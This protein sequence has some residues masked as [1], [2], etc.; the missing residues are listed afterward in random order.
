M[1]FEQQKK[2]LIKTCKNIL[3]EGKA[4]LI[5]GFTSGENELGCIPHFIRDDEGL[6]TLKWDKECTPNLAKYLLDRKNNNTAIIA[7]P[8]DARAIVMYMAESQI[9]RNSVYIIG[10]ECTGMENKEGKPSP[11]CAECTV[12]TPPVYDVLI[13]NQDLDMKTI[14][15]KKEEKSLDSEDRLARFQN[16]ISKCILC[17]SCRQACY[18]CYCDTC[19]ME[20]GVPNWLPSD[21][22]TGSKMIFHLGHAIHLAGR[23][24][25]C[26]ACE[27]A[28]P[29]GVNIRY[30]IN[31][32]SDFCKELYG[33]EAG[34]NPDEVPA[35]TAFDIKDRE[36]GF[37]GGED[38]EECC[39][40][41]KPD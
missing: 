26:G 2:E 32:L 12:R 29:S 40:T 6:K 33:Y 31:H 1:S 11:G 24:V 10:M 5:L 9:N 21:I 15:H 23:C 34:V 17:Y 20:R 27:R 3:D 4:D 30:L 25:G 35:M 16:E 14:K 41:K 38:D 19:F 13:K 22:D 7:K 28:C 39:D 18:G 8:C 36:V 37:L